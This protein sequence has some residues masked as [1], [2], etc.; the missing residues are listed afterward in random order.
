MEIRP[1][2]IYPRTMT[3]LHAFALLLLTALASCSST[4]DYDRTLPEG[5]PA[6]L[7][8]DADEIPEFAPDWAM[9]DE[10]EVAV[11]RS[12]TWIDRPHAKQFFP[13]EGV[14]WE[15]ARA[16]LVRFDEILA[17]ASTKYEFD[18][19]I[20]D[21]F[22]WYVSAGWD[23]H[24]GGVRF[25]GYCT[26]LLSGS[27]ERGGAY[28]YPL[29]ALPPDLVKDKAGQ[30]LGWQIGDK[31]LPYPSRSAIDGGGLLEGKGLELVW[32]A[33]PLDAFIAHVNGSAFITL[34]DGTMHRLGYAGKN[35]APYKSLGKELADDGVLERKGLNLQR[36]R[37]WASE[38]DPRTVEEYLFRNPSYVFFQPIESTPHGSL[39]VPV[40]ARRSIATDKTI[41]PRGSICFV[42]A[43]LPGAFDGERIQMSQFL[44]DQDT[45]GAI[46]TAGRTDL[47]FGIGPE[48][49]AIAGRIN[50][51]GQLYYLFLKE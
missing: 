45:G 8:I 25:T 49:E 41:F 9:R 31:L 13:C 40:T 5:A 14:T 20:R 27:L 22:Q 50:S 36:I 7:P 12:L 18:E 29:Y 23:G 43:S 48:A 32:L 46:R 6:L 3:R 2:R 4:P 15:R 11:A 39:D 35:G 37:A 34:P 21:E 47:Y 33:N 19:R 17:T 24:G 30:T 38:T 44:M 42:D 16:S 26:P 10:L 51:D 1:A 28:Q